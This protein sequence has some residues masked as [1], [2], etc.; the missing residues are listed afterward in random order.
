MLINILITED[1]FRV[2]QIH[3]AYINKIDG[4]QVVGSAMNAEETLNLLSKQSVHLLLL[5]IYMPDRLGTELLHEI[6]SP[7]L[8]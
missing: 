3:E 8:D 1:D 4:M 5:D 2:A 6:G 7:I